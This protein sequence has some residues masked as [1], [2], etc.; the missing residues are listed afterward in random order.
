MTNPDADTVR[1]ALSLGQ[2]DA[3]AALSRLELER[4]RYRDALDTIGN[5]L[6]RGW[7]GMND[8]REFARR[9]LDKEGT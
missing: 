7:H 9:A 8:M 2:S 6:H 4:D 1:E 3:L 5:N